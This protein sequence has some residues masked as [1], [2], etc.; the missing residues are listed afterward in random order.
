MTHGKN[1]KTFPSPPQKSSSPP[2]LSIFLKKVFSLF[3]ITAGIQTGCGE[4]GTNR[5]WN[6]PSICTISRSIPVSC[7][8]AEPKKMWTA[9]PISFAAISKS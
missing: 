4:N 6:T 9:N 7:I 1:K 2:S 8:T 3:V 5:N